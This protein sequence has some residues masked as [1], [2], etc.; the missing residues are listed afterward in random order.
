MKSK[1]K[2]LWTYKLPF[3]FL[4][5]LK[6]FCSGKYLQVVVEMRTDTHV[7]LEVKQLFLYEFEQNLDVSTNFNNLPYIKF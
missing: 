6:P 4:H 3:V 5:F 7:G 1:G 2:Y